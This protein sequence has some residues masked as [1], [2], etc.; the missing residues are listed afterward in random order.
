LHGFLGPRPKMGVL[1]GKREGGGAMLTSNELVTFGGSCVY[2][3]FGENR[4]RNATVRVRTDEYT[5]SRTH[6]RK[7]VLSSVPCYM[8]YAIAIAIGQIIICII[9]HRREY[10]C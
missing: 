6:R 7:P 4:R 1:E 8:L 9:Q 2:A 10:C 5:D 3:N